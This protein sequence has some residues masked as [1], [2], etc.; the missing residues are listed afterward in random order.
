MTRSAGFFRGSERNRLLLLAVVAVAGWIAVYSYLN[1]KPAPDRAAAPIEKRVPLPPADDSPEMRA[2]SD[3]AR[4]NALDNPAYLALL[5]RVRSAPPAQLAAESRRD[6][7]WGQV[8]LNPSRYRGIPLHI[9]GTL[10]RVQE[11][12]GENSELF[13]KGV[14]YEAWVGTDDSRPNFWHLIFD[15]APANLGI[16]NDVR[17][18]IVFDG[19][20]FKLHAYQASDKKWYAAPL[21]IGRVERVETPGTLDAEPGGG[22]LPQPVWIAIALALL[23]VGVLSRVLLLRRAQRQARELPKSRLPVSD[24][25]DPGALADWLN[26]GTE[27]D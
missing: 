23:G 8:W 1:R 20:F 7:L 10:L 9:D 17:G 12:F 19:Y 16:G 11:E 27:G 21:L 4:L 15:E 2:I 25:I 18:R 14:H 22:G 6:V 24:Q 5:E 13:P 3:R 26:A